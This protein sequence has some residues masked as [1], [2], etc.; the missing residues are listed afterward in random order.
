MSTNVAIVVLAAGSSTRMGKSKQLLAL[1]DTTLLG[2]VL[3]QA[4][5]S[6]AVKT[7]CVLGANA[8]EIE[9]SIKHFDVEV[10]F[11]PH[12]QNG[13]STSIIAGLAEV[14]N[15]SFDSVLFV[16]G[17]QPEVS[18]WYLD[19]LIASASDGKIIA[20]SYDGR[21]GVP[22]L[23]PKRH[24]LELGK[25][26]GDLGARDFLNT[27]S[28]VQ[29]IDGGCLLDLDTISDYENYRRNLFESQTE[30]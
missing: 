7:F 3:A 20:S 11:N 17:D 14:Q 25:I 28:S 9:K 10:V 5:G 22:A 24:F 2:R 21:A 23:I 4:L 30:N 8:D 15:G 1:S 13:L 27:T 19:Q 29:K 12:F 26:E 6:K 16:L 18:T